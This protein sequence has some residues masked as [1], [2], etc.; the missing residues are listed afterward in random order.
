[1]TTLKKNSRI[2][3]EMQETFADLKKSGV[4]NKKQ[5]AEFDALKSLEVKAFQPKVIKQLRTKERLSQAVFAAVL[6]TSTST[7]QKWET[8]EKKPSG[9]SLKLLSILKNK[10]IEALI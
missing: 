5:M 6:N 4:I 10:G 2:I 3:E 7:I 8:G 1:M 9:P